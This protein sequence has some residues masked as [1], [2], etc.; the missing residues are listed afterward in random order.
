[1]DP[2]D[3]CAICMEP[4]TT[5]GVPLNCGHLYHAKCVI[6]WLQSGGG[7][8]TCRD[9]PAQRITPAPPRLVHGSN[10]WV[11]QRLAQRGYSRELLERTMQE[12]RLRLA[13]HQDLLSERERARRGAPSGCRRAAR[14]HPARPALARGAGASRAGY[15]QGL[16]VGPAGG[17]E[18]L[19]ETV[20]A[21][22]SGSALRSDP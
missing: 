13:R 16:H 19:P 9:K 4:L 2:T 10:E 14:S 11:A 15:I 5:E 20:G 21:G 7:C 12:A 6:P 1:M 3:A 8:P 22:H 17:G 18:V